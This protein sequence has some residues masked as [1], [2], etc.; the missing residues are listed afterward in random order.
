M[1]AWYWLIVAAFGGMAFAK[2]CEELF[3]WD[4]FLTE[5]IAFLALVVAYIPCTIW[6]IFFKLTIKPIPEERIEKAGLEPKWR[7][8]NLCFFVDKK[9]THLWNKIFFVRIEKLSIDK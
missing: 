2:I 8:G 5:M 4:N 3:D 7:C 6:N 9:A 1:V